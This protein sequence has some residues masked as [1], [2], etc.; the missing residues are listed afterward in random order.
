MLQ[1]LGLPGFTCKGK[2]VSAAGKQLGVWKKLKVNL[3]LQLL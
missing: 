1:I 2:E 3:M